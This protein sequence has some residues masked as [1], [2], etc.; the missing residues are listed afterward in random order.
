MAIKQIVPIVI[1]L[2]GDGVATSFTFALAN[3]YQ[4]GVGGSIPFG[5]TGVTPSAVTIN[6]PPIAVATSTVDANG[7]LT[8][9]FTAAPGLGVQY[10]LE[11]D[12]VYNSGAATST[13]PTQ[14]M[15]VNVTGGSIAVNDPSSGVTGTAVPAQATYIAGKNAGNLI[16][17][18]V[19]A[20]GNVGVN[21]L[22]PVAVTGTFWQA[23]QPVSGSVSV[24]NFPAT[25]TVSG[26]V[27]VSNF[28]ATQAVTGIF[29][30]TTQPI[31]GSVS[32]SN[33]PATQAVTGT[34]WQ[35]TQP[36]SLVSLPALPTG[37]NTIGAVSQASGPWTQ[38]LTQVGGSAVSLGTK[39]SASSISVVIASDQAAVPVSF[40][41]GTITEKKDTGRTYVSWFVDSLTSVIAEALISTP[42]NKGGVLQ[43]A[44]TTYTVTAGKTLRIQSI[45]VTMQA[46][47][48][49]VQ[50][51]KMRLRSAASVILSSPVVAALT[52][53][54]NGTTN[55]T[56]FVSHTFPDGLEIAGGQ[57]IGISFVGST[58]SSNITISIVGYEY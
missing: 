30:P 24:A 40:S 45:A 50:T 48:S 18:A 51:V 19:D 6:N 42:V 58:T 16:G 44:A 25:Q 9:T 22:G 23:T 35:A 57:Q 8:I 14:A 13:S 34:F 36:V 53:A 15:N 39:T 20:S 3:L 55:T 29:W 17:V 54:N 21:V 12:L 31:S 5:T 26:S 4:A 10:S 1:T 11:V 46:T 47:N 38:N 41:G 7:N 49:I 33:F 37:S 32:V 56:G 43:P 28:P 2:Q 27:S 52:A